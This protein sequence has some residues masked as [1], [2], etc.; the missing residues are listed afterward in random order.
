MDYWKSRK[1]NGKSRIYL[2]GFEIDI[3]LQ[4]IGIFEIL[5]QN[6]YFRFN[7]LLQKKLLTRNFY[8]NFNTLLKTITM[9]D[10]IASLDIL[11][12][13]RKG[14]YYFINV[15]A[16]TLNLKNDFIIESALPI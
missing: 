1:I 13:I 3:I 5:S 14:F 8:V 10:T 16:I 11:H 2:Y 7:G 9:K 6:L 12:Y 15:K 4:Y